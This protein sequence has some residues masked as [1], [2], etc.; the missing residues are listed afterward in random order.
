MDL[1]RDV[2]RHFKLRLNVLVDLFGLLFVY[3]LEMY[4]LLT[5]AAILLKEYFDA[6]GESPTWE[7]WLI[8]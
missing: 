2:Q 3:S 8:N 5:L 1:L 6:L 7:D 4:D